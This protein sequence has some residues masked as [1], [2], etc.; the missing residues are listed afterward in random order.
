MFLLGSLPFSLKLYQLPLKLAIT[1][2]LIMDH[3]IGK[4]FQLRN[5][6]I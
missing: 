5:I 2:L 4:G 6:H 3:F 1:L